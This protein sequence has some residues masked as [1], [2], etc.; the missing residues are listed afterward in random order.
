MSIGVITTVHTYTEFVPR[1]CESV[2]AL[3]TTPDEIVIAATDPTAVANVV[4]VPARVV[5]AGPTFSFGT[6]LNTAIEQCNTD[7]IAW[8]GV[9]DQYRAHALDNITSSDADVVAF[10]MH[11]ERQHDYLP[12]LRPVDLESCWIPC[13]SPFRRTMWEQLPFQPQLAPFEDWAFWVGLN[14]L[15]ARFTT[16]GRIDFQYAQHAQQ[17]VPPQEPTRTRI[18]EW[19]A[20]LENA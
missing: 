11:I 19:L 15:G 4:T 17:I 14:H 2:A 20:T 16:T 13:G 10:G 8:I 1:W 9:D 18:G 3:N 12:E 6:Y 5:Q 7:W